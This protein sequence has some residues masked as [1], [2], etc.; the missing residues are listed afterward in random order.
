M[1][2]S[3]LDS[4]VDRLNLSRDCLYV[5]YLLLRTI[6][7]RVFCVLSES[8]LFSLVTRGLEGVNFNVLKLKLK[9]VVDAIFGTILTLLLCIYQNDF[10]FPLSLS[11]CQTLLNSNLAEFTV[12][13]KGTSHIYNIRYYKREG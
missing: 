11:Y 8:S 9:S 6:Y 7:V 5:L 2:L 12:G 10:F 13:L 3:P 1:N 4:R